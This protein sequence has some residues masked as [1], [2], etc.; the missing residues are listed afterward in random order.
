M[1]TRRT[2][3]SQLRHHHSQDRRPG[4]ED[5]GGNGGPPENSS[6]D[7]PLELRS[8]HLPHLTSTGGKAT[9]TFIPDV[10]IAWRQEHSQTSMSERM[11]QIM[12][13][14]ETRGGCQPLEWISVTSAAR[15]T[16]IS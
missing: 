9:S 4:Q 10:S 11:I 13:Q 14:L 16:Q 1:G 8:C 12:T 2:T 6:T 3:S 5:S 15:L 7:Q